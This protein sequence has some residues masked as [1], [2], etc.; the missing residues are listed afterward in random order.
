MTHDQSDTKFWFNGEY[1]P[2]DMETVHEKLDQHSLHCIFDSKISTYAI[3]DSSTINISTTIEGVPDM[4]M[5]MSK[6]LDGYPLLYHLATNEASET[7]IDCAASG[8][9]MVY[10]DNF[11][12]EVTMIGNNKRWKATGGGK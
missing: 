5:T 10:A 9:T 7:A 8:W 6:V 4:E 2:L 11:S 1:E 3:G 12:E